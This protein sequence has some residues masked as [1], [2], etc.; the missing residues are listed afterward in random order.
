M[1]QNNSFYGNSA[2]NIF[3]NTLLSKKLGTENF[4]VTRET[5]C[6]DFRRV[7]AYESVDLVTI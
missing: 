2:S 5:E 1:A 7:A 4:N 3:K 6:Q